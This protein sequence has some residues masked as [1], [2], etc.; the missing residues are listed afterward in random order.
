MDQKAKKFA[1]KEA[2]A[3]EEAKDLA[4]PLN[5]SNLV[6]KIISR[7]NE[8]K[9][10]ISSQRVSSKEKP[11]K[12]LKDKQTGAIDLSKYLKKP[13][14][15]RTSAEVTLK[16]L[17]KSLMMRLSNMRGG[18]ALEQQNY[19]QRSTSRQQNASRDRSSLKERINKLSTLERNLKQIESMRTGLHKREQKAPT[20][21]NHSL[22]QVYKIQKHQLVAAERLKQA[23]ELAAEKPASSDGASKD[24]PQPQQPPTPKIMSE[25]EQ[26]K[27]RIEQIPT[28]TTLNRLIDSPSKRDAQQPP[29]CDS[30]KRITTLEAVPL[31]KIV[32]K[33]R[34]EHAKY[35]RDDQSSL[36]MLR[37]RRHDDSQRHDSRQ[38][39]RLT[40]GSLLRNDLPL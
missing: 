14:T 27:K 2:P 11:Q 31:E 40:A 26:L 12:P 37:A 28:R 3:T 16:S 25:I 9:L 4:K 10:A 13:D 34:V 18:R 1:K 35:Q 24:Q 17:N 36:K 19:T 22:A 15:V 23:L 21:S 7:V 30:A 5:Y 20:S 39:S 38:R 32:S 29:T 6:N 8:G 33:K